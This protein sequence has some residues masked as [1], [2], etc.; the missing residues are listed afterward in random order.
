MVFP[1]GNFA[2]V[3]V[4]AWVSW[5]TGGLAWREET[6]MLKVWTRSGDCWTG[7]V[8]VWAVFCFSRFRHFARLFW[9][10]TC[11]MGKEGSQYVLGAWRCKCMDC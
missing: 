6:G 10:Q 8:A 4:V 2:M 11:G 5:E 1:S 9:N 3:L 7:D